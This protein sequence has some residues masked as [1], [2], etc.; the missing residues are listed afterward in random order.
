MNE[1][2]LANCSPKAETAK[3]VTRIDQIARANRSHSQRLGVRIYKYDELVKYTLSKPSHPPLVPRD[4]RSSLQDR[5][6]GQQQDQCDK[7]PDR[8]NLQSWY[9]TSSSY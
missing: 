8:C 1:H 2:V 7:E 6:G 4:C 5:I 9:V 3:K